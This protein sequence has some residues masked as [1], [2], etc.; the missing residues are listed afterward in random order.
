MVSEIT[1]SLNY[2]LGLLTFKHFKI[3]DSGTHT[4]FL[5]DEIFGITHVSAR[6]A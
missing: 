6:L 3:L 1:S 5:G 2:F 4:D